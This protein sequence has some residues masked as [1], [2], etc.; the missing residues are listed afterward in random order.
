M[1]TLAT[2]QLDV[3]FTESLPAFDKLLVAVLSEHLL[4]GAK[5]AIQ[6]AFPQY[7]ELLQGDARRVYITVASDAVLLCAHTAAFVPPSG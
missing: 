2:Q 5:L 3:Y 1:I 7:P 6:L 4:L